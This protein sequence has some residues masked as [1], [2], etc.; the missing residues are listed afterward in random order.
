[1]STISIVSAI[2]MGEWA[3]IHFA[4]GILSYGPAASGDIAAFYKCVA[5]KL[6][7]S[8]QIEPFETV[9]E[10]GSAA[11]DDGKG[12]PY[13]LNRV[14][15][16]H[17]IN[18]FF[19][20]LQATIA[21]VG[22][23][24]QQRWVLVACLPPFCFDIGYFVAMDLPAI[25]GI[26]GEC[27]TYIVSTAVLLAA[28]DLK[29]NPTHSADVGDVEWIVAVV[30]ACLFIVVA[31]FRKIGEL[32]GKWPGVTTPADEDSPVKLNSNVSSK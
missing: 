16:Q 27:Q 20:G 1:M 9:Q 5:N 13:L 21:C 8:K 22:I 18:L 28:L 30:C 12:Y 29:A 31:A 32:T 15:L 4:A 10:Q 23:A 3:L 17:A 2:L 7:T 11:V 14:F 19:V 24:T 6:S 25:G 26:M